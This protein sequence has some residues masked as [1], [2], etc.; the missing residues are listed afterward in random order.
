MENQPAVAGSQK[1]NSSGKWLRSPSEW[2]EAGGAIKVRRTA[3]GI[4]QKELLQKLDG[5]TGQSDLYSD[6][7]Y[8]RKIEAGDRRPQRDHLIALPAR[9][10][11]FDDVRDVD[12]I[13]RLY[14]YGPLSGAEIR[15]MLT[16]TTGC[17]WL[18]RASRKPWREPT[19]R[20]LPPSGQ[21]MA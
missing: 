7:R 6:A 16:G 10:L 12:E 21:R 4:S 19:P 13:L 3:R 18:T 20:R 14:G 15:N 17:R 5:A 8:V 1:R 11:E 9:V 2:K